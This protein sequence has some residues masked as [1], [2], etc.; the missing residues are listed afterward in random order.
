MFAVGHMAISYLLG[1]PASKLLRTNLNMPL[2]IVLSIIPDVDVVVDN[3]VHLGIHRGPSHS[4]I[5]MTLIFIPIFIYY[6][7]TAIPYF[8]ALISHSL[9]GDFITVGQVAFLWPITDV[10]FGM[11]ELGSWYIWMLDPINL[12]IEAALFALTIFLI[13]RLNDWEAL[14]NGQKS[15][16]L[17][18]IPVVAMLPTATVGYPFAESML[19]SAPILGVVYL[20]LIILFSIA[21]VKS[22]SVMYKENRK[23]SKHPVV[24]P[25]AANF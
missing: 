5:V 23:G 8:L 18:I 15:N 21:I 11:H 10:T 19:I 20:F 24:A 1:R 7:K 14:F 17:L 25:E 4:L 9:I 12:V 13:R 3:I 22:L 16:L 6:R 2:L